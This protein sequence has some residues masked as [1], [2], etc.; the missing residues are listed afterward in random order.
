MPS[1][2]CHI[3]FQGPL[4]QIAWG[5]NHI[6]WVIVACIIP[7]LPWILLTS[8]LPLG[9]FDPYD[10]RLYC[11]AQ[12][13]LL[14]CL[15]F[16][17]ALACFCRRPGTIFLLLACNCLL[18][19]LLDSLEIKWGNGIHLIAPLSWTML[20][21]GLVW[22]EHPLVLVFTLAGLVYLLGN[23]RNCLSSGAPFHLPKT[24]KI[25][26]GL[27]FLACYLLAPTFFLD[28]MERANT[29]HIHTLRHKEQR[30]GKPIQFDRV[31][32]FA[33][34]HSLQTFA[35]ERIIVTGSQPDT[36]GR[37]SFR[38]H[39]L[40][41]TTFASDSHH[42]HRDHRDFDTLIGLFMACTLLLQSLILAHF[43]ARKNNQGPP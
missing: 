36:S 42:L 41:P 40:T 12:A 7:D 35:G 27:G 5:K 43:L 2:L 9:L 18:H 39:F 26:T 37:V 33:L 23:W 17:A 22:P 34:Q 31:H 15:F 38:G 20:Q 11:T 16:S 1:T 29:Y 21:Q 19:L 13:S 14:C 8:L 4:S 30:P 32:Y 6:I 10:L 3:G 25:S 28:Q 24:I